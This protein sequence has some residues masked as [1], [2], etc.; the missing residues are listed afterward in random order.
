MACKEIEDED[1][2]HSFTYSLLCISLSLRTMLKS[3]AWDL[4]L[5]PCE[6]FQHDF[7]KLPGLNFLNSS[8]RIVVFKGNDLLV[9]R[10]CSSHR[11]KVLCAC[12][13]LG[14]KRCHHWIESIF[15]L[16]AILQQIYNASTMQCLT[17]VLQS[18]G[19]CNLSRTNARANVSQLYRDYTFVTTNNLWLGITSASLADSYLFLVEK[20]Q[21]QN[22]HICQT[23]ERKESLRD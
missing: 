5:E 11:T 12:N 17:Q 21:R 19:F 4:R 3:W 22:T 18:G 13:H 2:H 23:L 6:D 16:A 10:A 7:S 1:R 9:W 20:L 14:N 8:R 15:D